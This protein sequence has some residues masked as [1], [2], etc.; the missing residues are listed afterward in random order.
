MGAGIFK[1]TAIMSENIFEYITNF[2]NPIIWK[3]IVVHHSLTQDGN[4]VDWGAI[5]NYHKSLGWNDI[6]YHCG[7]ELVDG[8]YQY[9]TGRP[10]DMTGA[11]TIG[12]NDTHLGICMV[13]NFDIVT[14]T[15]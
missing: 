12:L 11:H 1:E 8:K 7:L 15:H 3:G 14:P 5:R 6:G 2:K 13:G 10:L 4:V 9:Q